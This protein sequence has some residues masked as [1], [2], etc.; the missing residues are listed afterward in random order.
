MAHDPNKQFN[1]SQLLLA[2]EE[3]CAYSYENLTIT[4]LYWGSFS[5]WFSATE[6]FFL[7]F[8]SARRVCGHCHSKLSLPHKQVPENQDSSKKACPCL[9]RS[10]QTAALFGFLRDQSHKNDYNHYFAVKRVSVKHQPLNKQFDLQEQNAETIQTGNSDYREM[11]CYRI[12]GFKVI[13]NI[14][15][16]LFQRL[17][18]K[19]ENNIQVTSAET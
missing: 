14:N 9:P 13:C 15:S 12:C 2:T 3:K 6:C 17:M 16:Y 5:F 18:L 1:H 4:A 11:P 8:D 7:S 19:D 10:L